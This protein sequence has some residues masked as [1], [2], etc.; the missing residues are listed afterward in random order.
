MDRIDLIDSWLLFFNAN[1]STRNKLPLWNRTYKVSVQLY[2]RHSLIYIYIDNE[3]GN[4]SNLIIFLF[5]M[6][7]ENKIFS[8]FPI[9]TAVTLLF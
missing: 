3:K 6:K 4:N 9:K 7:S 5:L 2:I 8:L 1:Q